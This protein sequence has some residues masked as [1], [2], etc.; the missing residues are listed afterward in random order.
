MKIPRVPSLQRT[1]YRRPGHEDCLACRA[2]GKQRHAPEP[3]ERPVS[4]TRGRPHPQGEKDTRG[5]D[6]EPPRKRTADNPNPV[7][8]AP[9]GK[10]RGRAT[11]KDIGHVGRHRAYEGRHR[12]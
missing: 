12:R 3:P 10:H 4:R 5:L 1:S 7:G 2:G 6:Y 8:Y 11:A 9:S